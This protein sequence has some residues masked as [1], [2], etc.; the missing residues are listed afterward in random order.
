MY[1][2]TEYDGGEVIVNKGVIVAIRQFETHTDI[3][4]LGG[5]H[6]KVVETLE[7]IWTLFRL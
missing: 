5:V 3:E 7:T 4:C 6:V 1:R 2:L